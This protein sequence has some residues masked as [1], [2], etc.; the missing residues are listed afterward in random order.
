MG[1]VLFL[2]L[3][4]NIILINDINYFIN[5]SIS[6]KKNISNIIKYTILFDKGKYGEY[7]E[8]FQQTNFF[9]NNKELFYNIINYLNF[10][11]EL[12]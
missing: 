9:I 10:A 3:D 6:I 4:K 1:Y 8:Q 11:E 12:Y 7:F 5:E 2:L